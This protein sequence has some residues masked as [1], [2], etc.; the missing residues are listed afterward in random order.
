MV[1]ALQKRGEFLVLKP[2]SVIFGEML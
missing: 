2:S 1:I